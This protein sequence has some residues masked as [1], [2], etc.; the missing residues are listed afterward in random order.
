M[1]Q[2]LVLMPAMGDDIQA[3]KAGIMEIAGIFAINKADLPGLARLEQEIRAMQSLGDEG[4]RSEAAPI[5]HVIASQSQG[6]EELLD[7]I[8]EVLRKGPHCAKADLEL[9]LA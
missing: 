5:R 7:A 6:V 1:L 9:S 4:L 3:L 2:F 8:E